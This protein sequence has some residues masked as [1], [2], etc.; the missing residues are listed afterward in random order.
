MRY[1]DETRQ[2][3]EEQVEEKSDQE[4]MRMGIYTEV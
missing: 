3:V 4:E 1:L 2:E